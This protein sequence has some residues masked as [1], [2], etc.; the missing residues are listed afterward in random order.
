MDSLN[1]LKF[2]YNLLRVE[3]LRSA[4]ATLTGSVPKT[5]NN[6][7]MLGKNVSEHSSKAENTSFGI[8][9]PIQTKLNENFNCL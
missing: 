8:F 2:V 1:K 6:F 9:N 4:V 3:K 5:N 7:F